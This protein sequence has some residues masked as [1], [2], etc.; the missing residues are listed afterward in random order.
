MQY[1]NNKREPDA[2]SSLKRNPKIY[3]AIQLDCRGGFAPPQIFVGRDMEKN[4][5]LYYNTNVL[6]LFCTMIATNKLKLY[7]FRFIACYFLVLVICKILITF[8][9]SSY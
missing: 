8:I 5:S 9:H 4:L 3:T 1:G 6:S 7:S 2:S